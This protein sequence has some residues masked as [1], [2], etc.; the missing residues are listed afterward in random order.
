MTNAA[1]I[2]DMSLERAVKDELLLSIWILL[3]ISIL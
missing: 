1:T 2:L 3:Y